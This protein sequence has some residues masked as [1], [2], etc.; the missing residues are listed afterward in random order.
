MRTRLVGTL[1][2]S[3]VLGCGG[4]PAPETTFGV[5]GGIGGG[6]TTSGEELAIGDAH[7]VLDFTK[8]G[9]PVGDLIGW[10]IGRGTL[11]GPE[12]DPLHPEW[13]TPVR[14]AAAQALAEVRPGHG[15]A[16]L[17]RFSGLQID[18]VDGGDGYHF[19]R[20][21]A[22]GHAPAADDMMASFEYFALIHEV[23]A[24]PIVT[25]NFG[26]GTAIEAAA[27]VTHL[28]GAD[29]DDANVAA[30]T[31]WGADQPYRQTQ[32]ELGDESYEPRNTGHVDSGAYSYANPEALH[33]GDPPWHGRPSASAADYAAR[34][35]EYVAAVRAVEPEARFWVPLSRGSMAAWGGVEAA[36][37]ALAPLWNEPAVAGAVIQHYLADDAPTLGVDDPN[38][39]LFALA[40]TEVFRPGFARVRA[41]LDAARPGLELV[42]TEYHVAGAASH[43]TYTRTMEAAVGL[44]VANMLIFY[45]QLGVDA[46]CQQLALEFEALNDADRDPLLEPWYNPFRKGP[47]DT[48]A[49]MASYVTTRLIGEHLLE[50]AAPLDFSRQVF[51]DMFVKPGVLEIP[52]VHAAAFV[53]PAGEVGSL[54]ALHRDLRD[55]HTLTLDLPVGWTA[56]AAVQWAPWRADHNTMYEPVAVEAIAWAQEGERVKVTLPPHSLVALRFAAGG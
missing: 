56:T 31:H 39:L 49:P 15:R 41:A 18:G 43:E 19:Y 37:A 21:V 52:L 6:S 14:V 42:V 13:R 24:G 35:L 10:N 20:F 27:Y 38:Y 54:V 53:D 51:E 29:P 46:A 32:F 26:S 28:N 1:V 4:V 23:D 16:P 36:T 8:P 47:D 7:A 5:G 2:S 9:A 11:Y 44:G 3:L 33:G 50:R 12:G 45:A 34:A 17:M 40:G 30:R 22:P 48:A 25:L 55:S